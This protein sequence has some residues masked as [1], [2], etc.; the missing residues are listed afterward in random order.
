MLL[1]MIGD[2][3]RGRFRSA[4]AERSALDASRA[5]ARCV[6]LTPCTRSIKQFSVLLALMCH[7]TAAACRYLWVPCS[8]LEPVGTQ[9]LEVRRSGVVTIVP[10]RVNSNLKSLFVEEL[11]CQKKRMHLSS[12]QYLLDELRQDLARIAETGG[13]AARLLRDPYQASGHTVEGFVEGIVGQCAEILQRHSGLPPAAYTADGVYRGLVL[14]MAE[15]KQMAVSKLRLW[16]EDSACLLFYAAKETLRESHRAYLSFLERTLPDSGEARVR[17]AENLCRTKGLIEES[18]G[19]TND[20]GEPRLIQAAAEGRNRKELELLLT[21]G[22]RIADLDG[23]GETCLMKAAK[24]GHGE[25]LRALAALG[26]DI[27]ARVPLGYPNGDWSAIGLAAWTGH[28]AAV[29]ALLELNADACS[30]DKYG[31]SA[32]QAAAEGGHDACVEL[33][34]AAS[35]NVNAQYSDGS[36][37]LMSASLSGRTS[38]IRVLHARG[39]EVTMCS[40]DGENAVHM[41][42]ANGHEAAVKVLLE[43]GADMKAVMG[44]GRTTVMRAAANG[45]EAVVRLLVSEGA[46]AA[47]KATDGNTAL[48]L[49]AKGG[50]TE[51]VQSLMNLG[52]IVDERDGEG[53]TALLHAAAAGHCQTIHALRAGGADAT[54]SALDGRTAVMLAAEGGHTMAVRLLCELGVRADA[55][56]GDGTTALMQAARNGHDETLRAVHLHGGSISAVNDAGDTALILA[57]SGGHVAAVHALHELGADVSAPRT[58]DG[59]TPLLAAA[60]AGHSI[61][62]SALH[63]LKADAAAREPL[64]GLS[65][66]ALAAAGGHTEA[67][68]VLHALETDFGGRADIG[69]GWGS[70]LLLAAENGHTDAVRAL[71]ELRADVAAREPAT[72]RTALILAAANGHTKAVRALLEL[73]AN[74]S[75]AGLDGA[76]A[77]ALAAAAEDA[78]TVSLLEGRERWDDGPD[79]L[80][81]LV[82]GASVR[83][84]FTDGSWYPAVIA[85]VQSLATGGAGD[86]DDSDS[87]P[88]ARYVIDWDEED[89]RDRVKTAAQLQV[90]CLP[91]KG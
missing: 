42:A 32:V 69:G 48:T 58:T 19:E 83:A 49:A 78:E 60:A 84:L 30:A 63:E 40:G 34:C 20:L 10:V 23:S 55:A 3:D 35:A 87:V 86:D 14:E 62:I 75:A 36:T 90:W 65:A 17:A 8:F 13:A 39:A 29:Q 85:E 64:T 41:A 74:A 33:L 68:R 89:P 9:H 38:T 4:G 25:T 82:V 37:A 61:V 45:H 26:A 57:A 15:A 77:V 72:G 12:F 50:H 67:I 79:R 73:G 46:D 91:P 59:S 28:T 43:L 70:A 31:W 80:E 51:V 24:A 76:T 16:L 11:L 47:A 53:C 52:C 54:V 5:R 56:A 44:D 1:A 21:A 7:L 88:S 66:L 22:A 81:C 71:C 2:L 27:H 6:L 18:V